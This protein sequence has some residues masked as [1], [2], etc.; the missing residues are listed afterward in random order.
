M[1]WPVLPRGT[2]RP[3]RACP[4]HYGAIHG[5]AHRLNPL[6]QVV[7]RFGRLRA[8]ADRELDAGQG[9][10]ATTPTF[11]LAPPV[12]GPLPQATALRLPSRRELILVRTAKEQFSLYLLAFALAWIPFLFNR[13]PA[14]RGSNGGWTPTCTSLA[15][16]SDPSRAG[17]PGA[18][19][20]WRTGR[21]V[22]CV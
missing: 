18:R 22:R 11:Q 21:H 5:C 1:P 7:W 20:C 17:H 4:P 6:T 14:L 10:P 13:S 12:V 19:W 16:R 15:R 8:E 3:E 2:P 9:T